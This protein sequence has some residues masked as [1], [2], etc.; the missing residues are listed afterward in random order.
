MTTDPFRNRDYIA[1]FDS[2]V[3]E[4]KTRS[5][6]TRASLPMIADVAYGDGAREKLDIFLPEAASGADPVHI[7]IHGGYWRMFAKE[8]FSF[9]ADAATAAGAIAVIVGYDLMP[10]TRLGTIVGQI[11]NAVRWLT[12]NIGQY[13]GDAG[14][15][16]ISGHSAGAHL[17][18]FTFCE[19][20]GVQK[21]AS[22][23]LLSGVYEL[24][25]LQ[26][27]FLQPLI[28]LTDQEV[29][30]FSPLR[31]RHEAVTH[32]D[33]AYGERETDPFR[34]QGAEFARH[35]AGQGLPV[36]AHVLSDADHM[37]AVR[38]LGIPESAAG[39]LLLGAI[40]RSRLRS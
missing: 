16:S 26:S 10:E 9:I 28:G 19:G 1:N 3:E 23:V 4:Y 24:E 37:S 21:P 33:V 15:F 34:N 38:D 36:T 8:D 13:G 11:R 17:A 29:A 30:A 40:R 35:L 14:T 25:P 32:V 31:M 20:A 22:A 18:S 39:Q 27:S 5:A 7:F 2:L 6:A 12:A